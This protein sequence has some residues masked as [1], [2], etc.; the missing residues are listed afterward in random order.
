MDKG[1]KAFIT[2]KEHRKL[3]RTLTVDWA[4]EFST[5][6]LVQM[7]FAVSFGSLLNAFL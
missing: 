5:R 1:L 3:R 6:G 7:S 2:N 4:S